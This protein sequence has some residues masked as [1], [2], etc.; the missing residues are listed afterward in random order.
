MAISA[1][2]LPAARG[3]RLRL[4]L[5]AFVITILVTIIAAQAM[6]RIIFPTEVEPAPEV[7]P[8]EGPVTLPQPG[9]PAAAAAPQTAP[10]PKTPPP[11]PPPAKKAA[12]PRERLGVV[13]LRVDPVEIARPTIGTGGGRGSARAAPCD[14]DRP[15]RSRSKPR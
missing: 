2:P 6:W 15:W 7:K 4:V 10:E 14:R 8:Y 1:V 12:M 9:V 13:A 5:A 3:H 11:A